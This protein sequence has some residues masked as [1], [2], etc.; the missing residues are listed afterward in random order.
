MIKETKTD[1]YWEDVCGGHDEI[2][3][4]ENRPY[5]LKYE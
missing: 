4:Y 1:E 2:G 5:S 3:D